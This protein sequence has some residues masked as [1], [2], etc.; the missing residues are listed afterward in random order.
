MISESRTF[1]AALISVFICITASC[2]SST[3]ESTTTTIAPSTTSTSKDPQSELD[4]LA[5][6]LQAV[7][8]S[9]IS[10]SDCGRFAVVVQKTQVKFFEWEENSWKDAS[11]LLGVD[12]EIDP[13]LVTTADYTG[14]NIYEFL[15]SYNKDGQQGG[16]Q[17]GG[18]F[19]QVNC[20]WKWAKIKEFYDTSEAMDLLAYDKSTKELTAWGDGPEGRTDVILTFN[21]QSNQFD[22]QTLSADDAQYGADQE[23]SQT[24]TP[25]PSQSSV[26]VIGVRCKDGLALSSG[27]YAIYS[28]GSSRG[29]NG[30]GP[31]T[32]RVVGSTDFIDALGNQICVLMYENGRGKSSYC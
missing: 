25:A 14:D 18:I 13:Y 24:P 11:R 1:R 3:V 2:S 30:Q 21:S 17:F 6:K 8:Y 32:G 4:A 7:D 5:D 19:W 10:E 20:Q 9:R 27:C 29:I 28:N 12:R 22:A 26:S 15:V 16:H 31:W 23:T